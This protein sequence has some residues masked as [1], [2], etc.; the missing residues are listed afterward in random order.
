M[1]HNE[2]QKT[3][4]LFI[5][6][7]LDSSS[8]LADLETYFNQIGFHTFMMTLPGHGLSPEALREV[9]AEDWIQAVEKEIAICQTMVD[10]LFLLGFSGGGSLALYHSLIQKNIA[11]VI[12]LAPLFQLKTTLARGIRP[13]YWLEKQYKKPIWLPAGHAQDPARYAH[14]PI[15]F[16]F[17]SQKLAKILRKEFQHKAMPIPWYLILSLEDET[18]CSKTAIQYF[19]R[20][21]LMPKQGLLYSCKP[22]LYRFSNRAQ[23]EHRKTEDERPLSHIALPISPQNRHY[24]IQGDR[25]SAY[26]NV[27]IPKKAGC[28][29]KILSGT[30]KTRGTYNPDFNYLSQSILRFIQQGSV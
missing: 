5:H 11:G 7:L 2:P 22:Q 30:S 18:V 24:G 10:R 3:G 21:S 6:G 15:H 23:L 1:Q 16:A 27:K 9:S 20:P 26:Q 25:L 19:S 28:L 13:L 17:Q 14:F 12:S 4:I 8:G 29:E